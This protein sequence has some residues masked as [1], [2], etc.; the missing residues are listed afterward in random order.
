MNKLF[1]YLQSAHLK[2]ATAESCTGGAIAQAL[3]EVAGS[4]S[5]FDQGW[6][7][8]TPE[9]KHQ[10]L[11]VSL[12]SLKETAVNAEVAEQMAF[13]AITLSSADIAVSVTGVAGPTGGTDEHPVGCCWFGF[14]YK[15]PV[16]YDKLRPIFSENLAI[17]NAICTPEFID[18]EKPEIQILSVRCDFGGDRAAVRSSAVEFALSFIHSLALLKVHQLE[19]AQ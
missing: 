16:G 1:H 9:A 15:W 3:T 12:E 13:G 19:S 10:Q 6:V 11:G 18:G 4:S 2:I 5:W 17:S 7:T 8:Y 14:A